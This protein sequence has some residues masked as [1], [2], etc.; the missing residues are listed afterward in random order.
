MS[1]EDHLLINSYAE[2]LE[3]H[4]KLLESF[5]TLKYKK[6]ALDETYI[7]LTREIKLLKANLKAA[8]TTVTDDTVKCEKLIAM[9]NDI[10]DVWF[11]KNTTM[12]YDEVLKRMQKKFKWVMDEF[13]KKNEEIHLLK[14]NLKEA[15]EIIEHDAELLEIFEKQ[16]DERQAEANSYR[17]ALNAKHTDSRSQVLKI[18]EG[19]K[20][21]KK[22]LRAWDVRADQ[23][24]ANASKLN[25]EKRL[26][27]RIIKGRLKITTQMRQDI[28]AGAILLE[29]DDKLKQRRKKNKKKGE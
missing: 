2:Q 20:A 28:T 22:L 18:A 3:S 1:Q 24:E 25:A 29:Y 27:L 9:V 17:D 4:K 10:I 21:N 15:K 11:G 6:T 16:V 8:R 14:Y 23:F 19:L 5:Q 13:D 26:L 12:T 7:E